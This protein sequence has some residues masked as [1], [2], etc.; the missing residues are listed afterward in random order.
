[1]E[2]KE[3]L[4][5]I[6]GV[7][8][9]PEKVYYLG[10]LRHGSPYFYPMN[11]LSTIISIRRLKLRDKVEYEQ[12][13]KDKPWIKEK[14]TYSNFP[15]VGRS[16]NWIIKLLKYHFYIQIGWPFAIRNYSLGWKDKFDTPRFEWS[17]S[18]QILL[19]NLQFCI[20]WNAPI[21]GDE[22]Y[23]DNDKYYEM[24]LWYLHYAEKDIKK[25]EETWHW[26]NYETKKSTWDS[27]Y[28]IK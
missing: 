19:F 2:R 14:A 10:K 21:I 3:L 23:P 8:K 24:V 27:K 25:A 9:L 16:K 20:W 12:L 22:K 26:T 7:F 18:F 11:F 1:M 28:L 17:P 13:I 5:S 4:K 6:K 15:M